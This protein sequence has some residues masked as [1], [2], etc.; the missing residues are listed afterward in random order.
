MET[1]SGEEVHNA[2]MEQGEASI[3]RDNQVNGGR[4][5]HYDN[6]PSDESDIFAHLNSISRDDAGIDDPGDDH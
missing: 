1:D 3:Y 5:E 6:Y 2:C 4:Y